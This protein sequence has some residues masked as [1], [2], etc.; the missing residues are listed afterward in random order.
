MKFNQELAQ[1]LED[2]NLYAVYSHEELRNYVVLKLK[3]DDYTIGKLIENHLY[4]KFRDKLEF[5]GFKKYYTTEK[6]AYI[7]I[8]YISDNEDSVTIGK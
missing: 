7:Y 6:E 8:K 4:K 3:E 1:D 2:D 5:V